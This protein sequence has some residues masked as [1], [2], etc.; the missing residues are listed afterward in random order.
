M[1]KETAEDGGSHI[2]LVD[3]IRVKPSG[4]RSAIKKQDPKVVSMS[5][6]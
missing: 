1:R 2:T 5:L 4:R 6:E 3:C